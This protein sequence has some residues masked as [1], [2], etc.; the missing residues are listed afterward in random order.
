MTN[1]LT[2]AQFLMCHSSINLITCAT[3]GHFSVWDLRHI[4]EPLFF[5]ES[6]KIIPRSLALSDAVKVADLSSYTRYQ[7]H[8]NSIKSMEYV[9]L[10]DSM[11][12]IIAGGDDNAL[13][14]SLLA[15]R[16]TD[17][18]KDAE[19]TTV[20]IPDAHAASVTTIKVLPYPKEM[21]EATDSQRNFLVA[22]S[23][24]D[25]RI[26]I[27]SLT[28]DLEKKGSDVIDIVE[29]VNR[30]SPVADISSM[31]IIRAPAADSDSETDLKLLVCGVGMEMLDI[32]LS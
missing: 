30:Y 32:Q 20:S 21:P 31:D 23:G 12:I 25:H 29:K 2:R 4:L 19:V 24:N 18:A 14:I 16:T 8:Q 3:D 6:S 9:D 27:W 17:I 11:K 15:L 1:C 7:I 26:K 5:V 28:I 22:T 10:S 13:S